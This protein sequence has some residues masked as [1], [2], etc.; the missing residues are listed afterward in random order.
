MTDKQPLRDI[1]RQRRQNFVA[2]LDPLA[3]RLA[4]KALPSPLT[5]L[6]G[7][8]HTV[9]LYVPMDDEAP[10]MRLAAPLEA[11]GKALCLPRVIDR[12]GGMEFL[13]WRREDQLF[14]GPFGTSHPDPDGGPVAPDVI[15]A[16][17]LGFDRRMN[18]LGWG[19]GYYDRAFARYPDALRIGIA[20]SVQEYEDIPAEVW[21]MP[22]QAI[23][24]EVEFIEE[25]T[26]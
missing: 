15:I 9:A 6:I 10:V 12:L 25:V 5:R 20:W 19:G 3:H 1:A 18:R 8:A 17:L 26:A 22:L 23:L 7:D 13:R 24:T 2:S 21:D 16:P 4:F 11:M 14:P